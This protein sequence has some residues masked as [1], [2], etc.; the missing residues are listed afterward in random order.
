MLC[1]VVLATLSDYCKN[2]M[3]SC[4]NNLV[5]LIQKCYV[6]SYKSNLMLLI[7][8]IY[9][10]LIW[11]IQSILWKCWKKSLFSIIKY[12]F[13]RWKYLEHQKYVLF[14]IFRSKEKTIFSYLLFE[15]F[16]IT[17]GFPDCEFWKQPYTIIYLE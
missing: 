6:E 12:L 14:R 4:F 8:L 5:R 9:M 7:N 3:L 16:T 10:L 17:L 13:Q 11:S 1:P 2:F 15:I